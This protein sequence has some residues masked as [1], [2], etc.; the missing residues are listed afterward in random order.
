MICSVKTW[1]CKQNFLIAIRGVIVADGT[2]SQ[3][4]IVD[5]NKAVEKTPV[6]WLRYIEG[7]I[8]GIEVKRTP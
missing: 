5:V 4:T 8:Q 6:Q 7:L 3:E 2:F 1:Y